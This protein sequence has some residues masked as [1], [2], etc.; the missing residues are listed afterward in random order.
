MIFFSYVASN[1]TRH[2]LTLILYS[3]GPGLKGGSGLKGMHIF[4]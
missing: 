2:L 1:Q 4:L 3:G